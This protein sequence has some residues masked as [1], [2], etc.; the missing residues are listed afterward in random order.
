MLS[1]TRYALVV[2]LGL[3]LAVSAVQATSE[4]QHAQRDHA[5]L[6]RFVKKRSPQFTP[7]I[8]AG[9]DPSED[10]PG[11]ASVPIASTPSALAASVT[12]SSASASPSG[13]VGGILSSILP[14]SASASQSLSA[15]SSVS[16]NS[17]VSSTA[18]ASSSSSIPSSSTQLPSET[19]LLTS[20]PTTTAPPAAKPTVTLT[21][22]QNSAAAATEVPTPTGAAQTKSTTL[23]IIII[24]ASSVGG[25]AILWTIFRK[26]KLGRSSKFD[27]RLQ[28]I[29]W[30][31]TDDR[32]DGGNG[33]IPN[34]RRVHS[35]A[36]S[37]HSASAHGSAHGHSSANNRGNNN[38]GGAAPSLQPIPDH[39]F[40]AGVAPIGGYADLARGPSPP[41]GEVHRGGVGMT[42]GYEY[43]S[44]V[45]LHHQAGG[46]YGTYDYQGSR[47]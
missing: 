4:F 28:P 44:A 27:E 39:D 31:P 15:S 26:W 40:T 37:F 8:G 3:V 45:P 30:Q 10:N 20:V 29:D 14:G 11:T 38:A 12:A 6:K 42:R 1:S 18:S 21:S 24:V 36:S 13:L 35:N 43:D 47:Y 19:L 22:T 23:M 33:I 46:N 2:Y 9:R 16:S 25:V 41:M 32:D 17:S 7:V 5:S 34:H